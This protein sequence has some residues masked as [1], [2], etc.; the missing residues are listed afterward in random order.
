MHRS[1][2][3]PKGTA[4]ITDPCCIPVLFENTV[5]FFLVRC[6]HNARIAFGRSDDFNDTLA[7]WWR[8]RNNRV[9]W[10]RNLHAQFFADRFSSDMRTAGPN[11][12]WRLVGLFV[13]ECR[14]S[15]SSPING[16]S[17]TGGAA[18]HLLSCEKEPGE[19]F[20]IMRLWQRIISCVT[21]KHR[22]WASTKQIVVN[23]LS[24]EAGR[25]RA[26]YFFAPRYR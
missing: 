1:I 17:S 4:A 14:A 25:P 8:L 2:S 22:N 24:A 6:D 23:L 18:Q 15:V 13:I 9:I 3:C 16:Q 26:H 21:D 20:L 7:R 10:W 19:T 11:C 5:Q 12:L